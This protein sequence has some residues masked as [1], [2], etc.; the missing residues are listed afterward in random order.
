[1]DGCTDTPQ[2]LLSGRQPRMLVRDASGSRLRCGVVDIRRMK[3]GV[4]QTVAQA[5]GGPVA[6]TDRMGSTMSMLHGGSDF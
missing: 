6:T 3:G 1:M 5:E 2:K 4:K